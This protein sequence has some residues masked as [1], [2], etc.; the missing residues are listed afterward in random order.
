ML[1]WH[2]GPIRQRVR[3][4]CKRVTKG[5]RETDWW[6]QFGRREDGAAERA[7]ARRGRPSWAG[8]AEGDGPGFIDSARRN[9]LRLIIRF[10]ILVNTRKSKRH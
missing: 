2:A 6:D 1:T 9:Y 8:P 7:G 3:L 10:S 5:A 4:G